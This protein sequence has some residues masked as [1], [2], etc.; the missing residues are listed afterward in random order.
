MTKSRIIV[1]IDL[2]KEGKQS[3]YARLP[4]SVNRSAYGW[5]PIPLVSIK[6]GSGSRVLLLAGAHG[7]EYEGQVA[8][9][10]IAQQIEAQMITG[11]LII[12]PMAN[13]PA[14]AAG[15]RVSPI[16][17]GNLNR[18][19]PGRADGSPT[20]KIADFIETE[21]MTRVD[22]VIDLHSGGTSLNYLPSI[23][24]PRR[25]SVDDELEA[26]V[27]AFGAPY[28]IL[29]GTPPR[30]GNASEAASRNKIVRISTELGGG[31]G[32]NRTYRELGEDGVKRMLAQLNVIS[33]EGLPKPGET[34]ILE[35]EPAGFVF[36]S[37]NGI[38]ESAIRLGNRVERG[39]VAGH[40]YFPHEPLREP[41]VVYFDASGTVV[42]E[43]SIAMCEVGDCLMHLG[44]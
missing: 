1:D 35:A 29:F 3:G 28:G 43:R 38:F 5:L 10:R 8:L 21:L 12:M 19:Y 42:C 36:A 32:L 39:D 15:T 37:K 25:L 26:L 13:Y 14:A 4:H 44:R 23:M 22:L 40:I 7:D 34:T 27:R 31:G 41:E 11:Q 18:L 2:D 30:S 6:N 24:L 20:E 17:G 9:S 16:D 33:G